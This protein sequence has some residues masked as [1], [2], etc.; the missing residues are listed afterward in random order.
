MVFASIDSFRAVATCPEAIRT[1]LAYAR[2]HD[3]EAMAPGRYPIDGDRMFAVIT[4]LTTVPVR[5]IP[6]EIHKK[7]ID[8]QYWQD[9]VE[10]FGIAPYAGTEEIAEA[11]EDRDTWYLVPPEDESFIT[12]RPGTFAVFYPWD[13]HRP[14]GAA[15]EPSTFHKCVVKVSTELL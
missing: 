9:G 7:Y 2:E 14:G 11:H 15:G 6:P 12:T 4:D 1:A 5:E 3:V 10:V 8:V 13:V